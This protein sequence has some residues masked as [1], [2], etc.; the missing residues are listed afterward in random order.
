MIEVKKFAGAVCA[1]ARHWAFRLALLAALGGAAAADYAAAGRARRTF[2]FHAPGGGTRVEERMLARAGSPEEDLRRYVA[3]AL[4]GPE[5]RGLL[6]LFP[7]DARLRS[8]LFRGGVAYVDF[9]EAAALPPEG[10]AGVFEGFLVL[11]RG[12]RRNFPGVRDVRLFIEGTEVFAGEFGRVFSA[13]PVT[14]GLDKTGV[15][16]LHSV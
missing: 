1:A 13:S 6:R 12:I 14:R 9:S 7:G 11:N 3:E 5:T 16:L 8:L 4:L 10:A 2:E 15:R